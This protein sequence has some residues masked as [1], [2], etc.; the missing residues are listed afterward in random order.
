MPGSQ[1]VRFIVSQAFLQVQVGQPYMRLRVPLDQVRFDYD[2][3]A[4]QEEAVVTV[5]AGGDNLWWEIKLW[6][7][8]AQQLQHYVDAAIGSA[9]SG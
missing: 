1:D 3:F 8:D 4:L 9:K 5:T 6:P 7:K 2:S